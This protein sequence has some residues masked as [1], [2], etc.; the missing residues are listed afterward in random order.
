MERLKGYSMTARYAGFH[1]SD[2]KWRHHQWSVTFKNP[3][4]KTLSTQYRMGEF[5]TADD[6]PKFEDVMENL[7]MDSSSYRDSR[8]VEDFA[9]N[10]GYELETAEDRRRVGGIYN[11]CKSMDERLTAFLGDDFDHYAYPDGQ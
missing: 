9:A 11:A 1:V 6:R 10:F 7:I 4:G 3:A 8:D 2:D 5:W